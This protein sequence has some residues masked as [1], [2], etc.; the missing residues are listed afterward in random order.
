MAA[1]PSYLFSIRFKMV[2]HEW[3]GGYRRLDCDKVARI[4]GDIDAVTSDVLPVGTRSY[5]IGDDG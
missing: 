3:T 2:D 4:P 5:E 1:L